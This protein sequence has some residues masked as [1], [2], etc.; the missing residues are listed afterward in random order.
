MVWRPKYY[1]KII[2]NPAAPY[3]GTQALIASV[4]DFRSEAEAN[5]AG[6]A[7]A[8]DCID[9]GVIRDGVFIDKVD[10]SLTNFQN[11]VSGIASSIRNA[12]PISSA[13]GTQRNAS[14][15]FAGSFSNCRSN[16]Q[17]PADILGG[18][19]ATAKSRGNDFAVCSIF[20]YRSLALL[21]LAR[22]QVD[23]SRYCGWYDANQVKNF[24]K[25][26]NNYGA[27]V[28]DATCTYTPCDDGYWF[29][30]NEA[31]KTGS[32]SLFAKT[33]HNG[34][35][36]GIADL[37]GNQLKV[38]QGLT[39]IVTS[40][41]IT[42]AVST[43]GG[44]KVQFTTQS[45]HNLAAGQQ[46][47]VSGITTG[48]TAVNDRI[49]SVSDVVSPTSIKVVFSTA[50]TYIS[51]GSIS[52]GN[53]YILKESI[54]LK[55]ITGGNSLTGSDHFNQTFIQN[56]MDLISLPFVDGSIGQRLGNGNNQV[57]SGNIDRTSA[58]YKLTAAGLPMNTA[59][60][61]SNGGNNFGRDYYYEY[62]VNELCA[63][64][65]GGWANTSYAGMW[66]LYLNAARSVSSTNTSGRSCLYV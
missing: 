62:Y 55:D 21:A 37:N 3:Y 9:G 36:C 17:A 32:G 19:W 14:N 39:S 50:Q 29:G 44:T 23:S 12:N 11:G 10:W 35:N 51:G 15:N 65:A 34:E 22:A 5:A 33:T 56:N 1:F 6:Y 28:D 25:G 42:N 60:I 59:A 61:S 16:G 46:F 2:N 45:N 53:F 58:G 7:V 47:L 20:I 8:R 40:V 18:A 54:A 31:R 27:D 43:D 66:Y 30:R 13:S 64:L 49:F 63:R 41:N 38:G 24:P 48:M 57:L 52:K 26:N 4:Y